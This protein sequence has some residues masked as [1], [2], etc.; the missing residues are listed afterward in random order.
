[1]HAFA[2]LGHSAGTQRLNRVSAS[3]VMGLL[4]IIGTGG[5]CLPAVLHPDVEHSPVARAGLIGLMVVACVVG[6]MLLTL[7][8]YVPLACCYVLPVLAVAA[9]T[10]GAV[11]TAPATTSKIFLCWA[12]LFAA[13]F[14][15]P[16]HAW[17]MTGYCIF[18]CM[19]VELATAPYATAAA[20][21]A[22]VGA[23]LCGIT[24]VVTSI[25]AREFALIDRLRSEA[26]VDS[27]TGLST[28]RVLAS[29]FARFAS[30]R[31]EPVSLVVA[32][33]DGLKSI[34]DE[35]GHPA[36]DRV[37]VELA[38]LARMTTSGDDVVTRLGG[39]ETAV[40][41]PGRTYA[42]A[43]AYAYRLERA[44]ST[45]DVAPGTSARMSISVG[46]ATAPY[47]GEDLDALY[48]AADRRLYERKHAGR[49]LDGAPPAHPYRHERHHRDHHRRDHDVLE[50]PDVLLDL[51][52][53]LAQPVSGDDEDAVPDQ[54]PRSRQ[55]EERDQTH[56]LQP[57]RDRD[58]AAE[59]RDHPPEEHGL[60]SVPG[61][62]RL[63]TVDV[64]EFDE[65]HP[66]D[67]G[68]QPVASEQD[69]HVVQNRRTHY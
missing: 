14:Y 33:V 42:Q 44:I 19:T 2:A 61:E 35:F 27:L 43:I 32:D 57:G 4:A 60:A 49:Y 13:Y 48:A 12:V 68:P 9:W 34:N 40:L 37:L 3:R 16:V 26:H 1:M 22:A 7:S 64:V 5:V 62:P 20:R 52:P 53:A 29:A 6:I 31:P 11:L 30:A 54:A 21:I 55:G 10:A 18:A 25:R 8:E 50:H 59:D 39:D 47:D 28:R 58:Q 17:A 45:I 65:W 67:D 41:L 66:V 24:A 38:T 15:R 56:P 69:P 63:G 51:V 46:V 23:G 36:G